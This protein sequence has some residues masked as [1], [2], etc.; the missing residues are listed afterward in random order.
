MSPYIA[1]F[2]KAMALSWLLIII[3]VALSLSCCGGTH[4]VTLGVEVCGIK[5]S[6]TW[7]YMPETVPPKTDEGP[8]Q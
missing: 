8:R 4:T 7:C 5:S 3:A 2:C 1:G 6:V